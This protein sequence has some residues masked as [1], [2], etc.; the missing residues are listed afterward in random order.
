[1]RVVSI[2]WAR[3]R[4]MQAIEPVNPAVAASI[5]LISMSQR[6]EPFH[7]EAVSSVG[8]MSA[9]TKAKKLSREI[10]N[11]KLDAAMLPFLT[12]QMKGGRHRMM[13]MIDNAGIATARGDRSKLVYSMSIYLRG[14]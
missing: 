2:T 10:H 9:L 7:Q 6:T 14:T 1:M 5:S 12:C 8:Q 3:F 13:A 4:M 11:T